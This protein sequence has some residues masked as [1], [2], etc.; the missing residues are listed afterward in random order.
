MSEYGLFQ[1]TAVVVVGGVSYST[2]IMYVVYETKIVI[3]APLFFSIKK[4]QTQYVCPYQTPRIHGAVGESLR[5]RPQNPLQSEKLL[6]VFWNRKFQLYIP[7][8]KASALNSN[9]PVFWSP[10]RKLFLNIILTKY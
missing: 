8:L 4:G 2:L 9:S 6:P 7:Q 10:K 3:I 5:V 1:G